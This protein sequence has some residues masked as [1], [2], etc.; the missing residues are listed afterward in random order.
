MTK[1]T[2]LYSNNARSTLSSAIVSG[3]TTIPVVSSVGFPSPSVTG[4]HF[5]VTIDDGTNIEIVQ[6]TGVSGNSF[7]GCV[8]GQNGTSAQN[9]NS[10]SAVENRLT[11]GNITGLARLVDRLAT[12]TSLETLESPANTDGNSVLCTS[13]D[14]IGIPIIG[15]ING[16]TWKFWNY[17][18]KIG[19][20]TVG[21][22]STTTS[23][24]NTGIGNRLV[25][26]GSKAYIIQ[27]TSGVHIGR[28]RFLTISTNTISW[29]TALP[30]GLGSSDT[31]ELYHCIS[32]WKSA[33]GNN[34]DKVFFENDANL[35]Y[36]YTI[37]VGRNAMSAGPVSVASGVTVVV[38]S[39]SAWSIV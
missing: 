3:D 8:R 6:V 5:Y 28:C 29:A 16:T 2:T 27:F 15:V 10:T 11:Q 22:S 17:P 21:S 39:G 23:L 1:S 9:F 37:P 7:T 26:P 34:S 36:D 38:P 13:G 24:I 35:W 30:S 33:T 18:D 19:I 12:T 14:A 20:G 4:D 31:Y 25:D 32:S